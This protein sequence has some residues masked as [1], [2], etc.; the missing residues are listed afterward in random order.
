[1]STMETTRDRGTTRLAFTVKIDL[2][3]EGIIHVTNL[4]HNVAV[5]VGGTEGTA[6][7]AGDQLQIS[8]TTMSQDLGYSDLT[9]TLS[10][11]NSDFV[12]AA[13][14]YNFQGNSVKVFYLMDKGFS[15]N[16]ASKL[17]FRGLIEDMIYMD[18]GNDITVQLKCTNF[19]VRLG[20]S[21]VRR[22]T[23]EDQL[24]YYTQS[25]DKGFNFVESI[26]DQELVWG[27]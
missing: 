16:Y 10:G 23:K 7:P 13:R 3:N 8:N 2:P 25:Q 17:G 12:E 4:P 15:N 9:I 18:T 27:E 21:N 24:R 5:G 1:M 11:L 26:A 20:D 19:L 14:D 22:Y 6:T